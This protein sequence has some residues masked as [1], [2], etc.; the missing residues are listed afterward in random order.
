[1]RRQRVGPRETQEDRFE[2]MVAVGPLAQHMQAEVE[3]GG[4]LSFEN[5]LKITVQIAPANRMS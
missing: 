3:F 4:S 1:M 5:H 2:V